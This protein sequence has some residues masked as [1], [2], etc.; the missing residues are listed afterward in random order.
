MLLLNCWTKFTDHRVSAL[1]QSK[2]VRRI[3]QDDAAAAS[4]TAQAVKGNLPLS[5][6]AA[7]GNDRD[8]AAALQPATNRAAENP[9]PS[10]QAGAAS[11][12]AKSRPL[13]AVIVKPKAPRV[14]VRAKR[15]ADDEHGDLLP[16]KKHHH[17]NG[18][19]SNEGAGAS[20][21]AGLAAYGSGSDSGSAHDG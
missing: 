11:Q 12:T 16:D 17:D 1:Q 14:V 15:K 7:V 20:G 8:T 6:A 4:H 21:L 18:S 13:P 9:K 10:T 2:Q 19:N 3:D 5:S